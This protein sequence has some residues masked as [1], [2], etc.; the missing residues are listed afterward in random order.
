MISY[1]EFLANSVFRKA[2]VCATY[3]GFKF[4]K[5]IQKK[6]KTPIRRLCARNN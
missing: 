2:A 6:I 5:L 3:T 1:F 4:E